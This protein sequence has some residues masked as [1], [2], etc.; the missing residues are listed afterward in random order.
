[1]ALTLLVGCRA[2]TVFA[3]R[4]PHL[5]RQPGLTGPPLVRP[6]TA[7]SAVFAR[8]AWTDDPPIVSRLRP[9]EQP[10]RIT[11]HH[12]GGG[13]S[14]LTSVQAV[15]E[16]LQKIARL[17]ERPTSR[18]GLGAGDLAYH[19]VIDRAGHIW[20]GR[21]LVWQGAHAG[22]AAANSG[23]IGIVLLGNFDLQQLTIA[24]E[25]GLRRL[26]QEL[27]QRYHISPEHIY[28]HN[29][30]KAQYG[31]ASTRCPGH[32]LSAWLQEFRR[33]HTNSR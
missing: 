6:H 21:S 9:M 29:Q 13:T 4:V 2:Q 7:A 12:E 8:T 17:H 5:A 3:T 33:E 23:N 22:N 16:R 10:W 20:E 31:L 19:F 27:T 1:M 18:G 11:L 25:A 14:E 32:R 28:G 26:L 24:Q 30:I 15:A